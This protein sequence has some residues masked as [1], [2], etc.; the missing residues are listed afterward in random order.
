MPLSIDQIRL[1]QDSVGRGETRPLTW[2]KLQLQRLMAL[3]ENH[4]QEVLEALAADLGK[5]STEAFFEVVALRQE[6]KLASRTCADGC[7]PSGCRFPCRS[8]L[9]RRK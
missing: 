8:A 9:A 2:R 6:L 1:M 7:A 3:V 4:E 5:P